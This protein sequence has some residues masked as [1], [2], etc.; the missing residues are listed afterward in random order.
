MTKQQ[1]RTCF[2]LKGIAQEAD[3]ELGYTWFG[4]RFGSRL[5]G[6]AYVCYL[7]HGSGAACFAA[8]R[9]EVYQ[10]W[11]QGVSEGQGCPGPGIAERGEASGCINSGLPPCTWKT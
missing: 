2:C 10:V 3:C 7:L 4:S 8:R 11:I 1:R 5:E 6:E 9:G